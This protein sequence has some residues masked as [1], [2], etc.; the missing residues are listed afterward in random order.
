MKLLSENKKGLHQKSKPKNTFYTFN[1]KGRP[2]F[3]FYLVLLMK[4]VSAC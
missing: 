3:D 2:F 4:I 1:C